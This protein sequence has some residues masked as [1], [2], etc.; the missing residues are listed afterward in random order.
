MLALLAQNMPT[1]QAVAQIDKHAFR[2]RFPPAIKQFRSVN[3]AEARLLFF[4]IK[5][6]NLLYSHWLC[7]TY[8]VY[9]FLY[10][11]RQR[12]RYTSLVENTG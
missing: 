6:S 12:S 1:E 11:W 8:A 2:Y 10:C 4:A 5:K 7:I 3:F 9:C